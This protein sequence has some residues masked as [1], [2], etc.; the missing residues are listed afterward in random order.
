[1]DAKLARLRESV[2]QIAGF[3]C[4]QAW[5]FVVL[6]SGLIHYSLKGE[7]SH[8][9]NVYAFWCLGVVL[10]SLSGPVLW[11][12]LLAVVRAVFGWCEARCM[13]VCVVG[14][15]ALLVAATCML[16]AGEHGH[17]NRVAC[18]VISLVSGLGTGLLFWAWGAAFTGDL[19]RT[20]AAR[21]GASF[22]LGALLYC[23]VLQLPASLGVVITAALPMVSLACFWG[24]RTVTRAVEERSAV[25]AHCHHVFVR[26]TV[27]VGLLGFAESFM[28]AL[29]QGTNAVA[30]PIAYRG[31]FVIAAIAAA[32]LVSVTAQARSGADTVGR[33]NHVLMLVLAFMFLLSPAVYGLGFAADFSTAL[34]FFVFYLLTWTVLTQIAGTYRLS[35]PV[36]FGAGLGVAYAGCLAGSFVGAL[37][38]SSG[39]LGYRLQIV[40]SLGCACLVFASFLFVVDERT[41]VEL[42]DAN[43]ENPAG[44]RR[45]QLRCEQAAQLYGLTPKETEVMMLVAKGRSSQRIQEALGVTASTVNTHINHIYR[46]MD[47]HGRQDMLDIIEGESL[48]RTNKMA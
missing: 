15:V 45:F 1:M 48:E 3:G 26:A 20:V 30:D 31:G 43:S 36:A 13:K 22:A 33:V 8:L 7:I 10:L 29:F 2:L 5:S 24:S 18:S 4:V 46:K 44:P 37:L 41:F 12:R 28:R 39:E 47:V 9:N 21:Y 14:A 23:L 40:L 42:L 25:P 16:V 38:T 11:R 19:N 35:V 17:S 27:A 34:C 32:L 6:F